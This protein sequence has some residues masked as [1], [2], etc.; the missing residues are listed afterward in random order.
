MARFDNSE[1]PDYDVLVEQV[2]DNE[3]R[4]IHV[5][6]YHVILFDDDVHTYEYVI[7]MLIDTFGHSMERAFTMA[8]KVDA[9]G[10]VVVDTTTRERAELKRDQIHAYG[11]DW[12]IEHCKG[13]MSATVEEAE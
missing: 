10:W 2:V 8:R 11:A 6:P 9:A 5:P 1:E 4:P 7:E 13:S 3:V 12:R